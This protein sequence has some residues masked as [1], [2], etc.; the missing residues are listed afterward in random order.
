MLQ[1]ILK[2]VGHFV[3]NLYCVK[4]HTFELPA[5]GC[6]GQAL[7]MCCV[8]EILHCRSAEPTLLLTFMKT[9]F[10]VTEEAESNLSN[11]I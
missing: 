1:N 11:L 5:C 4:G 9:Q 2:D 7:L 3:N 10:I 8:L 6:L